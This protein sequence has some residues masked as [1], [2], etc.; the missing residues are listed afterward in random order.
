MAALVEKKK[1]K[2]SEANGVSSPVVTKVKIKKSAKGTPEPAGEHR[3]HA[4]RLGVSPDSG[5]LL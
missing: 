4:A 1:S 2:K 3:S 5:H